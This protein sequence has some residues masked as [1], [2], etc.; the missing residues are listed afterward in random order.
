MEK[1]VQERVITNI[2]EL[3]DVY[4]EVASKLGSFT[5]IGVP[6]SPSNMIN[7]KTAIWVNSM[8]SRPNVIAKYGIYKFASQAWNEA[9]EMALTKFPFVTHILLLAADEFPIDEKALDY[10]LALDKDVVAAPCPII[11]K[12]MG[13]CWNVAV[14][15]N[16]EH[17]NYIRWDKLPTEPFPVSFACNPWLIKREVVEKMDWPYFEDQFKQEGGRKIGQDIYFAQKVRD[18]G[19]ELWCEPRAAFEHHRNIDLH[20]A[21]EQFNDEGPYGLEWGEFA[22]TKIDWEIIKKIVEESEAKTILEFGSGLSSLLMSEITDVTSYE[23]LEKHYKLIDFKAKKRE[24]NKLNIVLWDGKYFKGQ[25]YD[26]A[27]VDGPVGIDAGGPGREISMKVAAEC[28]DKIIVH[29]AQRTDEIR[30]QE[31]YLKPN[32]DLI[33]SYGKC[34]YWVRRG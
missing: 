34:N 10:M 24:N 23:T 15:A 1:V 11:K 33:K 21:M 16:L 27:F 17:I 4:S 20:F 7:Y 14:D 13:I 6:I 3:M 12:H 22:I 30:L 28:C 31:K 9:V 32:F 19:F 2:P 25:K 18:Y 5:L 26:L 8:V 29:D